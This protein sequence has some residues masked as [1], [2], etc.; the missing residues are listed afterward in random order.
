[1]GSIY[2]DPLN[3]DLECFQNTYTMAPE[4]WERF[5]FA[6][7]ENVDF[8]K[9]Q[10]I[11]LMNDDGTAFSENVDQIPTDSGGIYVY[12]IVPGLI[13]GCGT[14]IMY[15]GM[16]SKSTSENLRYRVKSYQKFIYEQYSRERIHRLFAK[17]GK[18]VHVYFLPV[19]AS[20]E[21]IFE[22][23]TRLIG[24]FVPPC[25]ADIRAKAVKHAVRAF[26]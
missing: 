9:W 10:S 17:W 15:I 18:Y 6:D 16:A 2:N 22:L 19:N 26:R 20:K 21:V 25:N 1:M 8:S 3:C 24:S 23:E 7:L 12:S 14:Y 4:L 5:N 13:P 11:K